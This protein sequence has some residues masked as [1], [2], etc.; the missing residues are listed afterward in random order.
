MAAS[1]TRW[2]NKSVAR[3]GVGSNPIDVVVA[4]ARQVTLDAMADGW[5]GPPFDPAEL[6]VRLG[7]LI[8]PREDIRDARTVAAP[9]GRLKIEFNPNRP[10]GRV[11]YSIAHEI[12]HTFFPDCAQQVRHRADKSEIEG[13]DWQLEML[14]NIAAAELVMPIGS[15]PDL[16]DK[17]LSIDDLMELRQE[18]D[19]SIEALLLR[20]IRLTRSACALFAASRVESGAYEGRYRL[21]YAVASTAWTGTVPLG[22]HLQEHTLLA[23]CTAIGFT[24]KGEETWP[25]GGR[26]HIECVG[27][28]PYPRRLFP[29]VLGLLMNCDEAPA[30][31]IA[32]MTLA[33][34]ALR[35]RGA[36]PKIIAHIVNDRAITWGGGFAKQVA[37]HYTQA[38]LE[39]RQWCHLPGNHKLGQTHFFGDPKHIEIASMVAQQGYG[40]SETP[41]IRYPA[42]ETCLAAVRGRARAQGASVHMPRI[43]CGQA[44]GK[45]EVVQE[46]IERELVDHGIAVTVYDL[47]SG[48]RKRR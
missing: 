15:F 9:N 20:F 21:D 43:G 32:L 14:C 29:R 16:R 48:T 23:E 12:A 22:Q 31:R 33:G 1:P 2:T 28:P 37:I 25:N 46:L 6:A 47:P 7:L 17:K 36:G 3:L 19:V 13:D 39:F 26:F 4:K 44:G 24:A 40:T 42:L 11:R 35:P 41:R 8:E 27:I 45:W 38:Q 5:N 18:Y 30:K 34:D 10:R